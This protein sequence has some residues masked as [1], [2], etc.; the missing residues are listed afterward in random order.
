MF[1]S[2][3]YVLGLSPMHHRAMANVDGD[4]RPASMRY[5][6]EVRRANEAAQPKAGLAQDPLHVDGYDGPRSQPG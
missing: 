1:H 6:A 3:H 5:E 4:S 2:T